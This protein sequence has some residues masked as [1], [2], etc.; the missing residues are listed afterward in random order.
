QKDADGMFYPLE[1][2]AEGGTCT[3]TAC[4]PKIIDTSNPSSPALKKAPVNLGF[5]FNDEISFLGQKFPGF[6]GFKTADIKLPKGFEAY[7]SENWNTIVI[8]ANTLDMYI[9]NTAEKKAANLNTLKQIDLTKGS[10]Q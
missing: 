2:L 9:V 4:F 5:Q 7:E 3:K 8:N 1:P 10:G 6:V